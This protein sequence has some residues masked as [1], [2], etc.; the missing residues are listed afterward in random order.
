MATQAEIEAAKEGLTADQIKWLGNADPTDPFIRARGGLPPLPN[1]VTVPSQSDVNTAE[2][3]NRAETVGAI[4]DTQQTRSNNSGEINSTNFFINEERKENL[5]RVDQERKEQLARLGID[6]GGERLNPIPAKAEILNKNGVKTK[7]DIR[8][9]ITV[10]EEYL[11]NNYAPGVQFLKRQFHGIIFPY[12]PII[13]YEYNAAYSAQNPIHSN[14]TQ[15]FYQRSSVSTISIAGK[16]TVQNQK[17]AEIYLGT[18]HLLSI[19]TK[20]KFGND[21]YAGTPPPVCRLDAYGTYMIKNVP[22]SITSFRVE[23]PDTV[24]YFIYEDVM[25]VD[26]VTS[27]PVFSTLNISC[28]IMYSRREIQNFSVDKFVSSYAEQKNLGYL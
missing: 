27:I 1:Q 26:N 21:S 15:N 11:N 5:A 9:K 3:Y 17:D 24:D 23:L 10:P 7:P 4:D 19:L 14:Y 22:I 6:S 12:T 2:K 8:V 18:V 13:N 25:N 16:F 28:A 20:M